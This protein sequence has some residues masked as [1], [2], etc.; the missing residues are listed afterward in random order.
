MST[1]V[2]GHEVIAMML[3]ERRPYTRA[4]LLAAIQERF[5]QEAR[6]YTCM[7]QDL[8]AE[9]LLDFL[10]ERG[11]IDVRPEG[12]IIRADKVCQH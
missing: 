9:G 1:Q 5:G 8:T 4:S 6:F 2:F 3:A 7:A 10:A 11:K 12:I